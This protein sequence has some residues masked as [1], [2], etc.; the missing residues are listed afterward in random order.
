MPFPSEKQLCVSQM[1]WNR[2]ATHCWVSLWFPA[3]GLVTSSWGWSTS[4]SGNC[5]HIVTSFSSG[6]GKY[7]STFLFLPWSWLDWQSSL[8]HHI[9]YQSQ[10]NQAKD[11]ELGVWVPGYLIFHKVRM[12]TKWWRHGFMLMFTILMKRWTEHLPFV[13][14]WRHR[15]VENTLHF[16]SKLRNVLRKITG[17]TKYFKKSSQMDDM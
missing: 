1:G 9:P 5:C 6:T 10:T 4:S 14:P 12:G 2:M 3:G 16:F 13:G 15:Q 17:N 11:L 7:I 8:H